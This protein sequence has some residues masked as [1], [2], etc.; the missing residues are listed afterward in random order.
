MKSSE[1]E[2]VDTL[3]SCMP[4]ADKKRCHVGQIQV[5]AEFAVKLKP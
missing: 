3:G 2:V 4:K 1:A 5:E